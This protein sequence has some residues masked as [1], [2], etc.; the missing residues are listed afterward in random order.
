MIISHLEC[1]SG[2]ITSLP[3]LILAPPPNT[4]WNLPSVQ[5][6]QVTR[7]NKFPPGSCWPIISPC[8]SGPSLLL[9]SPLPDT[10]SPPRPCHTML[11]F[12]LFSHMAWSFLFQGLC[13]GCFLH[14]TDGTFCPLGLRLNILSSERPVLITHLREATVIP[15]DLTLLLH[16]LPSEN[17]LAIF[18]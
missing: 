12:F 8:T 13:V 2:L 9:Q 14:P 18:H 16:Y 6:G 11:A 10:S 3:V 4:F 7:P 15:Q 1:Y 5:E 17:F